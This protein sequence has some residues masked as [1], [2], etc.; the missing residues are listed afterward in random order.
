MDIS[1]IGLGY[2]GTVTAVGL[3]KLGHKVIGVDVD[4][5]KLNMLNQGISP[6][7]EKGI[8]DMLTD[9]QLRDSLRVTDSIKKS[10]NI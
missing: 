9:I 10:V 1:I 4:P 3:A 5:I 2:V 6:V 8:D 7:K